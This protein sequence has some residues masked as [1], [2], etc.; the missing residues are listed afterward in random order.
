MFKSLGDVASAKVMY[1]ELSEVRESGRFPFAKWRDI[2]LARK[3]PRKI[4]VQ[5]NTVIKDEAMSLRDYEATHEGMIQSWAERFPA[6]EIA[7]IDG[8]LKDLADKDRAH[9]T[10]TA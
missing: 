5:A 4:L 7:L 8:H 3:T 6:D 10:S 1:D 2:V 9:F